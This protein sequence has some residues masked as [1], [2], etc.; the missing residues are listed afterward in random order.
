MRFNPLQFVI[1]L[2]CLAVSGLIYSVALQAP[3]YLDDV[4][5]ILQNPVIRDPWTAFSDFP[6][7]R[8]LAYVSFALNYRWSDFDPW[9]YHLVNIFIH[10]STGF[11]LFQLLRRLTD[12]RPAQYFGTGLFLLHPAQT[13][14]VTYI[15]QRMTSLSAMFS[16]LTTV[17]LLD[18][19]RNRAA[20][21]AA[22]TAPTHLP[23][24]C[25]ALAA[26]AL[27]CLSK[28]TAIVLPLLLSLLLL[29]G[30]RENRPGLKK[31]TLYLLPFWGI[32]CAVI[33]WK[34]FGSSGE[35][36]QARELIYYFSPADE[37]LPPTLKI[38][39]ADQ[40]RLNYLFTQFIVIWY[41][42]KLFLLPVGQTLDYGYPLVSELLNWKSLAGLSGIFGSSLLA[43]KI[44]NR[45]P[46]VSLG[47]FWFF[48]ALSLES[49]IF[50]LD[51]IFEHRLYLPS[52]GL[53]LILLGLLPTGLPHKIQ[54]TV[55]TLLLLFLAGLS[56]QRNNLWADPVAFWS[57]N[58]AKA[59]HN[60]RS[61]AH[62]AKEQ[63]Q[64]NDLDGA[65]RSATKA[66]QLNPSARN[67]NQLGIIEIKTGRQ[68]SGFRHLK[69][70][71]TTAA[72][73][74][75]YNH[76]YSV[77]LVSVGRYVEALQYAQKAVAQ[78]PDSA[79]L[80][81]LGIVLANLGRLEEAEQ[82]LAK[83]LQ[84]LPNNVQARRTLLQIRKNG[85]Q[86]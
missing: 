26:A 81:N 1:F 13:Q 35:L 62:L 80:T 3:W 41:Y 46:L 54:F 74:A 17:L 14:A 40:V 4:S 61:Y 47:V 70:A 24:Y 15:V 75:P 58:V 42:L 6:S 10:G 77:A 45:L 73:Y 59:P 39:T 33:L 8:W 78:K 53:I 48:V 51:T 7:N 63:T 55:I 64:L 84:L 72:N 50:P 76:S 65:Y 11:F 85:R 68:A 44:R 79:Y 67:Y 25:C 31:L 19:F 60:Y 49:S 21:S 32:S 52:V 43:W 57:D 30:E 27:A 9:S 20:H 86:Q 69:L 71:V 34:L 83:A 12:N 29:F 56:Y 66:V 38:V 36:N 22:F 18:A 5:S 37:S 82:A 23:R 16:L 28:E 2:A